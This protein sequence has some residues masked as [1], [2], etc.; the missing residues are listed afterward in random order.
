MSE[1]P[2]P[3]RLEAI[4]V[5]ESDPEAEAHLEHCAECRAY[6]QG[7]RSDRSA[8]LEAQ[9]VSDFF[10]HPAIVAAFEE[11]AQQGVGWGWLRWLLPVALV[12]A[13]AALF[14][15]GTPVESPHPAQPDEI[16]FKG[17][18]LTVEV[19]RKRA[20]DGAQSVHAKDI[21]V[22]VGDALRV[23]LKLT[24]RTEVSVGLLADDGEW[25]ALTAGTTL[26]P[27][28]HWV[29]DDAVA[30][31]PGPT[32]GRLFVGPPEAVEAARRGASDPRV[33]ILR[34]RAETTP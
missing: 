13:A 16:L 26:E 4:M 6:I 23:R 29:S 20:G 31:G 1:H 21:P 14:W 7:L 22:G 33:H 2:A 25:L 8:M 34:I 3:Y 11:E 32:T 19:V 27:G 12:G 15:V 5:G 28:V 24:A 17:Q 30:I 18:T 9:P 10:E